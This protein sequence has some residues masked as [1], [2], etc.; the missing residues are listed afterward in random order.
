VAVTVPPHP[1][2]TIP[3]GVATCILLSVSLKLTPVNAVALRFCSEKV[4]VDTPPLTMLVGEKVFVILG[5]PTDKVAVAVVP[6]PVFVALTTLV[7]F[8]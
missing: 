6:L 1:V 4:I 2:F 7:V 3:L 8:V 5:L